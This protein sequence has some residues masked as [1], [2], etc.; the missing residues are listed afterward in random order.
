M[1]C[2]ATNQADLFLLSVRNPAADSQIDVRLMAQSDQ[3]VKEN[4]QILQQIVIAVEFLAKQGLALR[5]H[6][7]D[8]VDVTNE[9]MNRGNFIATLQLMV[10][11]NSVQKH[12]S[13]AKRNSKYTIKNEIIHVYAMKI[14]EK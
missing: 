7:D 13:S 10:K 6:R 5:G 9:D 2:H 4:T 11:E 8:K 3:Q 12:L 1:H 14:K